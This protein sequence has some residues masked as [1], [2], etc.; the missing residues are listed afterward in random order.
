MRKSIYTLLG[1]YL[2][3]INSNSYVS[4]LEARIQHLE[5]QLREKNSELLSR[6]RPSLTPDTSCFDVPL[7]EGASENN[8]VEKCQ[9]RQQNVSFL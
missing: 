5:R 9:E 2:V 4:T 1:D 8:N 6:T 7:H 3:L